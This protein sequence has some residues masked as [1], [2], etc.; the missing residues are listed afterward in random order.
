LQRLEDR[1]SCR[2]TGCPEDDATFRHQIENLPIH[3]SSTLTWELH[4]KYEI[5]FHL[6]KWYFGRAFINQGYESLFKDKHQYDFQNF[7]DTR[8][9]SIF[10]K[11]LKIN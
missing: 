7:L 4:K 5:S 1:E 11:A 2:A 9:A 3:E 6:I 10:V 8:L